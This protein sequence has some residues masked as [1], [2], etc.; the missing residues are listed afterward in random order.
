[1]D[2]TQKTFE[3]VCNDLNERLEKFTALLYTTSIKNSTIVLKSGYN[4]TF[5]RRD[6][7]Q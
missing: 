1:M 2:N 3:F 5:T 6:N 7:S 4:V